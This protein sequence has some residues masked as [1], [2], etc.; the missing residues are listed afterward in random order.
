MTENWSQTW[1]GKKGERGKKK[2]NKDMR[3]T[4]A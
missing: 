1:I 2:I 3:I 4:L